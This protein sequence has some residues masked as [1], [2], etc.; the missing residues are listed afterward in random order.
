M[1]DGAAERRLKE[2]EGLFLNGPL[3]R[4]GNGDAQAFSIETLLDILIVLYDECSNSSLR[5]EKTVTD[6]LHLGKNLKNI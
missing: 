6:F 3:R 1:N 5:R 4:L 2:L